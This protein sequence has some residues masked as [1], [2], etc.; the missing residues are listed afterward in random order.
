MEGDGIFDDGFCDVVKKFLG[1]PPTLPH[2]NQATQLGISPHESMVMPLSFHNWGTS[3][4]T[5]VIASGTGDVDVQLKPIEPAVLRTLVSSDSDLVGFLVTLSV[6]DLNDLAV[7][8]NLQV[9]HLTPS[10]FEVDV[11]ALWLRRELWRDTP[12]SQS[13][14]T[15]YKPVLVNS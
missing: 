6:F 4:G 12:E 5:P 3:W 2:R 9:N 13:Q 15:K 7:S 10:E 8:A 1:T 14:N 11:R